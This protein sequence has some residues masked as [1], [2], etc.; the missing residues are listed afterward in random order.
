MIRTT[1]TELPR[2]R[3]L[4]ACLVE[5]NR[6]QHGVEQRLRLG[7]A[8]M[9]LLWLLSDGEPRT[10]RAIAEALGLEQSTVN[11]Q[12][13]AAARAGRVERSASDETQALLVAPTAEGLTLFEEDIDFALGLYETAL[14]ELGDAGSGQLVDL[15]QRFTAAY[16]SAYDRATGRSA[17]M[18]H[19]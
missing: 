11:R 15:F 4:A 8:E 2:G 9:R 3:A 6:V 5:V 16:A 13:N 7:T 14:G 18:K 1:P 19:L 12:V 10:L 17:T